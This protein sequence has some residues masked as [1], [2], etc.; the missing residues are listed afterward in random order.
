MF[1]T[2]LSSGRSMINRSR[3]TSAGEAVHR[4]IVCFALAIIAL[5]AFAYGAAI[6]TTA[7]ATM[8]TALLSGVVSMLVCIGALAWLASLFLGS[9][10][11]T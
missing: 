9:P 10:W 6:L 1:R 8:P 2:R 3:S 11:R 7:S 4:R 5:V